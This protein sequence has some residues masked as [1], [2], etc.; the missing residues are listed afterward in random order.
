MRP[1]VH[2]H[3]QPKSLRWLIA[4]AIG[5]SCIFVFLI[6]TLNESRPIMES[7][8][9]AD[10][11]ARQIQRATSAPALL[12]LTKISFTINGH[13][14]DWFP[15]EE[16]VISHGGDPKIELQLS[17]G[18]CGP[19][20]G[21][22]ELLP[23]DQ[24]ASSY[25]QWFNDQF[26]LHPF[27]KLFDPGVERGMCPQAELDGPWLCVRFTSGGATPGDMYAIHVNEQTLPDKWKMWVSIFPLGGIEAD[28][29]E[30]T[31]VSEELRIAMTRK[32]GPF[33]IQAEIHE[34]IP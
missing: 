15:R 3:R 13:R 2:A 11:L 16:R 22:G 29:N 14:Y 24:C 20:D 25:A 30:W 10:A 9:E 31:T 6:F 33:S 4:G 27:T 19:A 34:V 18:T 26:W 21:S 5:F 23:Q 28:W 12:K 32:I 7:S 1:A 8:S 17:T